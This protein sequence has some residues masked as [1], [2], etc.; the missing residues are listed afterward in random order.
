[1]KKKV[2]MLMIGLLMSLV[3]LG[4]CG[5]VDE[6]YDIVPPVDDMTTTEEE[7]TTIENLVVS[8]SSEVS[9]SSSSKAK[10]KTESSS[11]KAESS[12]PARKIEIVEDNS[13]AT[14][15][16]PQTYE[17]TEETKTVIADDEMY[18]PT[19]EVVEETREVEVGPSISEAPV[20]VQEEAK[21]V[22]PKKE[23]YVVYKPSTH[24]IHKS[25]CHWVDDTCYKIENTNDIEAILCTECNPDMKIANEYVEPKPVVAGIDS[26]D[27][28][29]LAEIVWHEYGSDWVSIPEKA[30]IV[31]GVMNRVNDGRF[32]NTVYDVLVQSGQFS[33]F[34]INSCYPT[35]S[36][37]DAVDYYFSHQNEFGC[38]NSWWGDGKWNHFY[39]Q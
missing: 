11:S 17:T 30:R 21:K 8:S 3:M 38:E 16:L 23:T 27:R 20:E 24:Y 34:Y 35:Q 37:Y 13:K 7:T 22:E 33:G 32:P 4:S 12:A 36:C 26:Y 31:A 14:S 1:M 10:T 19:Y 2:G 15:T 5:Q 39:Y 6:P 25:D 18:G 29:L 9:S 28:Q